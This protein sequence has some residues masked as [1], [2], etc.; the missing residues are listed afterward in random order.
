MQRGGTD[1]SAKQKPSEEAG[2]LLS[3]AFAL[4]PC[5]QPPLIQYTDEEY[6]SLLSTVDPRWTRAE[7]D[8]LMTLCAQF[9]LRWNVIADRYSWEA[10]PP[11]PSTDN[12]SATGPKAP[13]LQRN[14]EDL[15]ARYYSLAKILL[16]AREGEDAVANHDF[17][18]YPY[19]YAHEMERKRQ[20]A[21]AWARVTGMENPEDA[22]VLEEAAA[23]EARQA[24][25]KQ[26]SKASESIGAGDP[27]ARAV[28]AAAVA[29]VTKPE[30]PAEEGFPSFFSP[31]GIP[32]KPKPGVYVRSAHT[33]E[34]GNTQVESSPLSSPLVRALLSPGSLPRPFLSAPTRSVAAKSVSSSP[35]P[36][37]R[38]T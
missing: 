11:P 17:V 22:R 6:N 37:P 25:E 15:K 5:P 13:P 21:L 10:A 8:H 16:V 19:N 12:G 1:R 28:V 3:E 29:N 20:L 4:A 34:I 2:L 7:T 36:W 14:M 32:V 31:Q 26:A 33:Q 9:D 27:Q 23:I 38:P 35:H 24:A 30:V 18:R